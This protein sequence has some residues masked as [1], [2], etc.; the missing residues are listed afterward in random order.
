MRPPLSNRELSRRAQASGCADRPTKP[1]CHLHERVACGRALPRPKGTGRGAGLP[2]LNLPFGCMHPRR[3]GSPPS[4]QLQGML[5]EQAGNSRTES[6]GESCGH[7]ERLNSFCSFPCG[8]SLRPQLSCSVDVEGLLVRLERIPLR[9][10]DRQPL[11]QIP[12]ETK[13]FLERVSALF[14]TTSRDRAALEPTVRLTVSS[15]RT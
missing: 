9:F 3:S 13:R 2:S 4:A 8:V 6:P 11:R 5:P 15:R 12:Q 7:T 10:P 14:R 1:E